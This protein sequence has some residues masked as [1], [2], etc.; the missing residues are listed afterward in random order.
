M[1]RGHADDPFAA[2]R[3][4]LCVINSFELWMRKLVKKVIS[5]TGPSCEHSPVGFLLNTL[6]ESGR[7]ILICGYTFI[8]V[9]FGT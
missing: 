1:F 8:F 5:R 3:T 2:E 9:L 7:V 4:S 6:E